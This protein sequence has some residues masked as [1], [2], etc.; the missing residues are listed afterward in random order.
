VNGAGNLAKC[1][2]PALVDIAILKLSCTRA[3]ITSALAL[4]S[5]RLL[6]SFVLLDIGVMR[7]AFIIPEPAQD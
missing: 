5:S 4:H 6:T 7:C 1:W 3:L 2:A